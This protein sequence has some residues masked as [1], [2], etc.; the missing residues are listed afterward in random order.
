MKKFFASNR[1]KLVIS[2]IALLLVG[3]IISAANG[4]GETAQSSVVGFVFKPAH[5]VATKISDA[6]ELISK[7]ASGDAEYEKQIG[8]LK[9][10]IGNLQ[11]DLADYESLKRQNE[12]YKEFLE[13]KEENP[14]YSFVEGTVIARDSADLYYSFNL[15]KGTMSGVKVGDP[16]L[17][18]KYI[19]GVVAK[20]YP[21]YCVVRTVLDP[22]FSIS[23]YEIVSNEV[24]YACGDAKLARDGKFKLANLKSDT[25]VSY[26]SIICTA[27]VSG[28]FPKNLLLGTVSEVKQE[29]KDI[30]SYAIIEPG[31]DLK[32]VSGCFILVGFNEK[33]GEE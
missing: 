7:N 17:F 28:A 23:A 31:T 9:E 29:N 25:A 15:N 30:S 13:L 16:V 22:D 5:I 27:G 26:G 1:F 32:T 11:S 18:G 2:I 4:H 8:Q 20:A 33:N 6:I 10:Q 24:Y 12:L 21:N 3:M 14:D 19:I